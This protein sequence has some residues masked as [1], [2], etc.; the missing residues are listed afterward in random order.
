MKVGCGSYANSQPCVL[1]SIKASRVLAALIAVL[2]LPA[3]G[4]ANGKVLV[5][6][7]QA[8]SGPA[9]PQDQVSTLD[10]DVEI[11]L[12]GHDLHYDWATGRSLR[13]DCK[14]QKKPHPVTHQPFRCRRSRLLIRVLPGPHAIGV[15]LFAGG[16]LRFSG[17]NCTISSCRFPKDILVEAGKTHD[18]DFQGPMGFLSQTATPT[19]GAGI[20]VVERRV[21]K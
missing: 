16:S 11:T 14:P 3:I 1:L 2:M 8:Y 15:T 6:E 13:E 7:Y 21:E 10:S 4:R 5:I 17:P 9:L 19:F 20:R 12:D 18:V